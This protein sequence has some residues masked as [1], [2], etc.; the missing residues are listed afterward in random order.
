[1]DFIVIARLVSK[2]M[3]GAVAVEKLHE[4]PWMLHLS[5]LKFQLQ[6]NIVPVGFI[7]KGI[8]CHRALLFKVLLN[9]LTHNILNCCRSLII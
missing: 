8:Y 2:A 3:G 5:E 6:S 7:R 9:Y 4:F 1:M